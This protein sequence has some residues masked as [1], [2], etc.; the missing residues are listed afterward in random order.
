MASSYKCCP[1][2]SEPSG[3]LACGSAAQLVDGLRLEEF[4]QAEAPGPRRGDWYF[5]QFDRQ[6]RDHRFDLGPAVD[7]IAFIQRWEDVV[8]ESI[9]Q[10]RSELQRL[11]RATNAVL[12]R[13]SLSETRD[14]SQILRFGGNCFRCDGDDLL[15]L[16]DLGVLD[17]P[18]TCIGNIIGAN[19]LFD[20]RGFLQGN[21]LHSA[22]DSPGMGSSSASKSKNSAMWVSCK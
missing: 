22:G 13:K 8:P 20:H 18:Q 21:G 5:C 12:Y 10:V 2:T 4:V 15:P 14:E 6:A 7:G 17:L 1:L 16:G 11:G 19:S 9:D 3:A